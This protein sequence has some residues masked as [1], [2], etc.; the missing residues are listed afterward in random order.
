MGTM[1]GDF[2]IRRMDPADID[3]VAQMMASGGWTERRPFLEWVYANPGIEALVGELNGRIVA[4]GQGAV[5]GPVGWVGSIFTAPAL[6]GRGFGRAM[7]EAACERLSAAGCR[8]LALIASDLGRPIYEKLGFRIDAWYEVWEA[9]PVYRPPEAPTGTVLRRMSPADLD[10]VVLLDRRATGED[11][12]GLLGA[13]SDR[14]WL[15]EPHGDGELLGF[16]IQMA[17]DSGALI[18]PDPGDAGSLLALLR[19]LSGGLP[20]RAAIVGSNRAGVGTL[21][22]AGFSPRFQTP[23]MLLGPSID[24]NPDLIW[25]LLGFAFG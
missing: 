6:R 23:R 4:T 13:L 22:R 20:A 18:A 9:G 14:G 10:R 5:N 11:R 15:L 2:R 19:S 21:E 16:L 7:T 3:A 1:T 25:G 12:R 17:P 24:W 8:T